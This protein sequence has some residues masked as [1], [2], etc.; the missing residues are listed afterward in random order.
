MYP[1]GVKCEDRGLVGSL[2]S[3]ALSSFVPSLTVF[4]CSQASRVALMLSIQDEVLR[5]LT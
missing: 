3:P 1:W 2:V 5:T 4:Y